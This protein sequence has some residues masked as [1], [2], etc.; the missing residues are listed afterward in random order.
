MNGVGGGG[1]D[2]SLCGSPAPAWCEDNNPS[3]THQLGHRVGAGGPCFL[4]TF[5]FGETGVSPVRITGWASSRGMWVC[6]TLR[7]GEER[8]DGKEGLCQVLA[9]RLGAHASQFMQSC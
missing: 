2:P 7:M 3:R 9:V 8:R 5:L 4:Q 6:L 1:P